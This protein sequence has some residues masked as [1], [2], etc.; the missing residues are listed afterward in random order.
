M[1]FARTP[2][3]N[4]G[5]A[6]VWILLLIALVALSIYLV[7]NQPEL[8]NKYLP[9]IFATPTPKPTPEAAPIA[10]PEPT[11]EAT[12]IAI[13][14]PTPE[15]PPLPAAS[16]APTPEIFNIS[17]VT[18]EELP[19]A[20]KILTDETFAIADGRGSATARAGTTVAVVS[21]S[22]ELLQISYLGETK[23]VS[24]T[25][26][27]LASDVQSAR[28][29]NNIPPPS[30]SEN[31]G[32][33]LSVNGQQTA[34]EV[35][36]STLETP[37]QKQ[38]ALPTVT[39]ETSQIDLTNLVSAIDLAKY[40]EDEGKSKAIAYLANKQI[41]VSGVIEKATLE[42]ISSS[43]DQQIIITLKTEKSLP[44]IKIWLSPSI[45]RSSSIF[46]CYSYFPSWWG[47]YW[48]GKVEF[49]QNTTSSIQVRTSYKHTSTSVSSSS[50]ISSYTYTHTDKHS[51]EWASIFSP[52]DPMTIEGVLKG[53]SVD[54]ELG[55]GYL[56]EQNNLRT[57][58]PVRQYGP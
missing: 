39:K 21:R 5:S 42:N 44:R 13:P 47:D 38:K 3:S 29:K 23:Q 11:P 7:K 57:N 10:I 26:T 27:S 28:M 37:S 46:K 48:G 51:S 50:G 18:L 52:G 40:A 4:Q 56:I 41:K 49:R 14:E 1:S 36:K 8:V 2:C 45:A 33:A 20:V 9:G 54:V 24:Y 25:K 53:I 31:N 16:V 19:K 6:G 35:P 15:A 22:G 17:T 12:P 30:G 58:M 55:G 43:S 34:E 32:V